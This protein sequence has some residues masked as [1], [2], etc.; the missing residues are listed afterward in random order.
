MNKPG[1]T[2]AADAVVAREGAEEFEVLMIERK[3]NSLLALPA[4]KLNRGENSVEA[5]RRETREE[6]GLDFVFDEA[7][8]IFSG[9][10]DDNRATDRS[11]FETQA[12]LLRVAGRLARQQPVGA[13][14][15]RVALWLPLQ[16]AIRR[17]SHA[18]TR[19][20]LQLAFQ[21]LGG[22]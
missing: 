7:E 3:D 6:T 20:M 14:D 4:G 19:L 17:P 12:F 15:A 2:K 18:S 9:A 10:V 21:Q 16:E 11:W 22:A 1:P 8:L 5:V 13:D